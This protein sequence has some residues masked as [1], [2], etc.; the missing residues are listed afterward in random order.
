MRH[1]E[2]YNENDRERVGHVQGTGSPTCFLYISKEP[3]KKHS[4]NG[5]LLNNISP[6]VN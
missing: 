2:R 6:T 4:K 1:K 5:L 3:S